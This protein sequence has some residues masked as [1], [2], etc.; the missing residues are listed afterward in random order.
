MLV[1]DF[2]KLERKSANRKKLGDAAD[3]IDAIDASDASDQIV[4]KK[5]ST[6]EGSM[7]S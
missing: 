2:A 7:S 6:K 5:E 1:L 4:F 3:A